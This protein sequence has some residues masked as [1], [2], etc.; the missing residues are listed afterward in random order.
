MKNSKLNNNNNS[1]GTEGSE[2]PEKPLETY[3]SN[4]KEETFS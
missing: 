3:P 2:K 1:T 4:G